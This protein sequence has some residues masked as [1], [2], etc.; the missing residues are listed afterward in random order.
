MRPLSVLS[1]DS[2][3][4]GL[5]PSS[6][7]QLISLLL[8]PAI[9]ADRDGVKADEFELLLRPARIFAGDL[10]PMPVPPRGEERDEEM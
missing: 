3:F 9:A 4:L 7:L 6:L 5:T 2:S 1:P 10:T 8:F